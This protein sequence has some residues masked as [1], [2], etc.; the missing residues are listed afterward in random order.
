MLVCKKSERNYQAL[1]KKHRQGILKEILKV[2]SA[3]AEHLKIKLG[4]Q[5][6]TAKKDLIAETVLLNLFNPNF[7]VIEQF[8]D[9]MEE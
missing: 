6:S 8:Y 4:E 1:K 2:L 3:M 7:Y 9:D 5:E